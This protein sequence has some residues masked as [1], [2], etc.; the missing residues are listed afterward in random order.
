VV[1]AGFRGAGVSP[2]G[3]HQA[4]SR[5]APA[6]A[7]AQNRFPQ[8]A[9]CVSNHFPAAV[10]MGSSPPV[11]PEPRRGRRSQALDL[12]IESGERNLKPFLRF[13][14]IHPVRLEH[15]AD[16]RRSISS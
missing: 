4:A 6:D 16:T 3:C 13:G 5:E 8:I 9:G 11:R 1:D 10:T 12:L 2:T 14:L 7:G 15:V